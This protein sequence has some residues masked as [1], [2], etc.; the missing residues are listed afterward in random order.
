MRNCI[1][2]GNLVLTQAEGPDLMGWHY[3]SYLTAL[4]SSSLSQCMNE[5]RKC[6]ESV[7]CVG[8]TLEQLMHNCWVGSW[9]LE[10]G[11]LFCLSAVLEH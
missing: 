8:G 6:E 7:R 10:Q 4:L 1:G 5:V 9:K 2:G 3:V 11:Q